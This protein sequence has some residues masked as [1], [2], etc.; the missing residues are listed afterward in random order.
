MKSE[1]PDSTPLKGPLTPTPSSS[2]MP[3]TPPSSTTSS[4][5]SPSDV[6]MTHVV[7]STSDDSQNPAENQN[8]SKGMRNVMCTCFL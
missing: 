5:C 8:T 1:S 6:V 2:K 7:D 3:L 4:S